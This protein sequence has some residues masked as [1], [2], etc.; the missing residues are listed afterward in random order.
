[1]L[2]CEEPRLPK[3][4]TAR[5]FKTAAGNQPVRDFLFELDDTDRKIVGKD[6]AKVEFG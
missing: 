2:T 3:R 1:M 6:I 5:F 4:I